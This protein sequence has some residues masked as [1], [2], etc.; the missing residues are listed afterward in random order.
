M[1]S[2]Q[3]KGGRK[4]ERDIAEKTV[5]WSIKDLYISRYNFNLHINIKHI[6]DCCG[7]CKE[8]NSP[9]TYIIDIANNQTLRDFVMTII[10]EL[11][12]V[13][14]YLTG[15]W[16]GDGETEAWELQEDLTDAIWKE[17]II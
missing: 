15:E 1:K 2:I 16:E 11:I 7:Y 13:R 3:I 8:G 10:H 4:F 5:A 6:N 17:N 9:R 12:H 14:Q